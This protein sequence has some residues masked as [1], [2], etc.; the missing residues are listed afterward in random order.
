MN[1]KEIQKKAVKITL[2]HPTHDSV[3][4]FN[5]IVQLVAEALQEQREE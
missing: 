5:D 3:K 4:L 2:M 1:L